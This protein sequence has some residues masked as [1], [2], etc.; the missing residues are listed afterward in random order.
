M[1]FLLH[2]SSNLLLY[3]PRYHG[4][5]PFSEMLQ[6]GPVHDSKSCLGREKIS[7]YDHNIADFTLVIL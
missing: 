4:Y 5:P 6:K 3:L 7:G 1:P 2:Q